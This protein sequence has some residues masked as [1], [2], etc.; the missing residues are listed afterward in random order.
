ME[1][2]AFLNKNLDKK[3]IIDQSKAEIIRKILTDVIVSS[4]DYRHVNINDII[5]AATKNI[6][7][8]DKNESIDKVIEEKWLTEL[9]YLLSVLNPLY[10][11]L[12]RRY[13][14]RANLD[15]EWE[16]V[17]SKIN[18][19][20]SI[21]NVID[22][23]EPTFINQNSIG[24]VDKF[25]MS[26][27]RAELNL[28]NVE[29]FYK[30]PFSNIKGTMHVTYQ[31][32]LSTFKNL[33][34][35]ILL[36]Y[37]FRKFVDKN[38]SNTNHIP[39]FLTEKCKCLIGGKCSPNAVKKESFHSHWHSKHDQLTKLIE[40]LYEGKKLERQAEGLFYLFVLYALEIFQ[41]NDYHDDM[42]FIITA[43]NLPY[44]PKQKLTIMNRTS[45]SELHKNMDEYNK[46]IFAQLVKELC[47]D[48]FKNCNRFFIPN[49]YIF[50][51][52]D[53][54]AFA[55]IDRAKEHNLAI[56]IRSIIKPEKYGQD[57]TYFKAFKHKRTSVDE[58]NKNDNIPFYQLGNDFSDLMSPPRGYHANQQIVEEY[59]NKNDNSPATSAMLVEAL[60]SMGAYGE[61]EPGYVLIEI[62]GYSSSDL[63]GEDINK[64]IKD[65]AVPLLKFLD[66]HSSKI[67]A[68]INNGEDIEPIN[69]N[70][71]H[72]P[73]QAAENKF[74]I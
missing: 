15:I 21:S 58:S 59:Q 57:R 7:E 38:S 3:D 4:V 25:D 35:E 43:K 62:R 44:G 11:D 9:K 50:H 41:D 56:F 27:V 46:I 6:I 65:Y 66:E 24:V 72:F 60:S 20:E 71:S 53:T 23:P 29:N 33:L 37:Y 16:Q 31:F 70:S 12:E 39:D 42:D 28:E 67:V 48:K 8:I 52:K 63:K 34:Q 68:N 64:F 49:Y 1:I 2:L 5:E 26:L 13:R 36:L 10:E 22:L 73:T 55:S 61:I 40:N 51:K 17:E 14:S 32:R 19:Y 30:L 69:K 45:F 18:E 54:I 47:G 74:I